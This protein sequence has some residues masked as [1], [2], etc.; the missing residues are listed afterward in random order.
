MRLTDWIGK[1]FG[2]KQTRLESRKLKL[3]VNVRDFAPWP[4][5]GYL[6]GGAVRDA[7]LDRP[8]ADLDWLV[9]QPE[10]AASLAAGL[11]DG[12]H[13]ALDERRGH[14][15]VVTSS[16][17]RDYIRLDGTLDANLQQRDFTV[18]SLALAASGEIVDPTGGLGDLRA[19]VLRMNGA[20]QL[21]ADPLRLLRGVRLASELGLELEPATRQAIEELAGLHRSGELPLPAWERS[22]SELDRI[23]LSERAAQGVKLLDD[24]GLLDAYL[25]ELAAGR[26]VDQGGFHHLD[27]LGHQID[28]LAQLLHHFP[29]ADLT[30]RW[31][32]LLHDVGKPGTGEP[33][34]ET[35]GRIRFHGHDRTGSELARSMMQRLRQPSARA[36]RV[37]ALVRRHMQP[38]PTDD[39][40]TGRFIHRYGELLPDLLKLMVADRE[41]ARG[42]LASE[43]ARKRYRVAIG[44]VLGQLEETPDTPVAPLFSGEE[45]MEMLQ[46]EPGPK[47]GQ[48]VRYLAELQAVGDADTAEE[49]E[50]HLREYARVQWGQEEGV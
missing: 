27:V 12:A 28:A 10:R 47:V 42:R 23:L 11:A 20:E 31:A 24:L 1:L 18:N 3:P 44:R 8:L 13:F 16:T 4:E 37:A 21:R 39:K 2:R 22:R 7:L 14:W 17:I 48:A 26:G 15:R 19:G 43:A 33:D 46:L 49:A 30:L 35:P 50:R 41:A 40:A 6:V 25:P 9:P 5:G 45:L 38:L 36:E 32:T 29:E 34:E